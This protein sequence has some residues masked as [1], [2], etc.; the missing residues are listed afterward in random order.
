MNITKK[1]IKFRITERIL[2][3]LDVSNFHL[4]LSTNAWSVVS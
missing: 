2:I 1:Y 4:N 3:K